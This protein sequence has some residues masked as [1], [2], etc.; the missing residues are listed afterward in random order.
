MKIFFTA[1][2]HVTFI[3]VISAILLEVALRF[4][5]S[6]IPTD[7][8]VRFTPDIRSEIAAE[9]DLPTK[10]IFRKV[11]RD[12]GGPELL[13]PIPRAIFNQGFKDIGAVNPQHTDDFGFCNE[14]PG[15]IHS[16]KVEVIAI[17]DSYTWCLAVAPADTWVA[18]LGHLSGLSTYNMGIEG[19]GLYE[20][21]QIL[22]WFGLQKK[23]QFV[24]MNVYEGN[25]LRD[26]LKYWAH[27][28][29]KNVRPI[30]IDPEKVLERPSVF[31]K[32]MRSSYM[33]NTL[34]AGFFKWFISAPTISEGASKQ[35]KSVDG[36]LGKLYEVL[37]DR[38]FHPNFRF[39]FKYGNTIVPFNIQN[40][41]KDEANFAEAIWHDKVSLG[42]FD[43]ALASF[44][45][46]GRDH[47]FIPVVSYTPAPYTAY[48][49][50]VRFADSS[51]E[52]LMPFFS[53]TQRF[54]FE[55]KSKEIG[56]LYVDLTKALQAA[57]VRLGPSQLLYFPINSHL[58]PSGHRVIAQE[59]QRTLK[60]VK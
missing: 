35:L 15:T 1:T 7:F 24:I 2:G 60:A 25:D 49:S 4:Y 52:N 48:E 26:A 33:L 6:A 28:E 51:L 27:R 17:G 46:L 19:I 41:D 40:A 47:N 12:D 10:K 34:K 39:N 3:L 16:D 55:R 36:E 58:T 29:S 50:Q 53:N 9:R 42:L 13:I 5:P 54:Y 31:K 45:Q 44:V 20:E 32:L 43:A 30:N 11:P 57:A 56:F 38:A 8:L 18:E 14:S 59:I 21:L 37:L 23:P 22:K